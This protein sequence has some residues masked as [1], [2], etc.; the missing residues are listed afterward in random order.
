MKVKIETYRKF[1]I[2]FDTENEA[3]SSVINNDANTAFKDMK[4]LKESKSYSA[5]KKAIDEYIKKNNTFEPFFVRIKPSA[6]CFNPDMK[7]IKVI[8]IRKDGRFI[9]ETKKGNAVQIS[10]YEEKDYIL[11]RPEDEP[12]YARIALL[13]IELDRITKEIEDVKKSV[14]TESLKEL[15]P[16]FIQE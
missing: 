6:Y 7:R 8:G 16:K 13:G 2:I 4:Q 10:E 12:H 5:V 9:G 11:E 15:K 3:F 1:D 14:N